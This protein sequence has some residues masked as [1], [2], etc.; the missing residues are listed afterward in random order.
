LQKHKSFAD[1]IRFIDLTNQITEGTKEFAFYDTVTDKFV[2]FSGC[3][4]WETIENFK[5][6]YSGNQIDR[7]LSLIPNDFT[8]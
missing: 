5:Q 1:M 3:Q 8:K 7:Y 2:L 4:T 6:D